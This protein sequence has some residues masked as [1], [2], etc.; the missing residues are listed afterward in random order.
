[1]AQSIPT[2]SEHIEDM[3]A[4]VQHKQGAGVLE[5]SFSVAAADHLEWILIHL[6]CY[7]KNRM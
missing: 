6:P 4:V 5:G 3:V 2:E 1:M 7:Y